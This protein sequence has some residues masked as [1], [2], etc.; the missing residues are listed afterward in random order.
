MRL[1]G[2]DA[3]CGCRFAGVRSIGIDADSV[4]RSTNGH[5][6]RLIGWRLMRGYQRLMWLSAWRFGLTS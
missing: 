1:I 5:I 4:L 2:F 3:W 6:S